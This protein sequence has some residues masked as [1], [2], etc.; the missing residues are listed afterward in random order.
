MPKPWFRDLPIDSL[1]PALRVFEGEERRTAAEALFAAWVADEIDAPYRDLGRI[2]QVIDR[3]TP[4]A[5][6]IVQ[7]DRNEQDVR[8][9]CWAEGWYL[10]SDDE[11]LMLMKD[12][13]VAPLLE[14][15]GAGCSKRE[16]ATEIVAHHLRDSLHGALWAPRNKP[17]PDP[18]INILEEVANALKR[19][20]WVLPL[21]KRADAGPLVE[22]AGRLA[23]YL[24]PQ[25]V[26]R[27]AAEQRVLDL[28]RC[29]PQP[30][31]PVILR[32]EKDLWIAE[33]KQASL[34]AG[35][36]YI[37]RRSG[38]MWAIRDDQDDRPKKPKK[39]KT[40]KKTRTPKK[41]KTQK[42]TKTPKTFES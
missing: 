32:K 36:L 8:R 42:K 2:F 9:W 1:L 19:A 24:K 21:A 3:E 30:H 23:S 7:D 29:S 16:Y 27:D 25:K 37:D 11:D 39:T 10:E 20:V 12:Q 40:Q 41:T 13:L 15:V 26:A 38:Q 31:I 34:I 18:R 33:F 17:M 28:R 5:A 6:V 22:Y 4:R 14:E 35:K